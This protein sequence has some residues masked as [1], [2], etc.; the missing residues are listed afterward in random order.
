M[1]YSSLEELSQ[2]MEKNIITNCDQCGDCVTACSFFSI[3]PLKEMDPV[4]LTRKMFAVLQDG[5]F[6]DEAYLKA[7][8]CMLCEKC[9]EVCPQELNPMDFHQAVRN[10]LFA[11]GKSPP[12]RLSFILPQQFRVR[13][14]DVLN[15]ILIKPSE[16]R[17][18]KEAPVASEKK[19][20]VV[21]MGCA[22]SAT[23]DKNLAFID[24]LEKIIPLMFQLS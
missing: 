11:S 18:L 10:R 5:T 7:F 15:S 4:D 8:S 3:S 20:V 2:D 22:A 1:K 17:W 23:P 16:V 12:G 24:I 6:S 13:R 14:G 21:F 9:V 19:E